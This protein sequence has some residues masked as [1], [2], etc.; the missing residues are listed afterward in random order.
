MQAR[1]PMLLCTKAMFLTSTQMESLCRWEKAL[2]ASLPSIKSSN[3]SEVMRLFTY[4]ESPEMC[5]AREAVT[6][7]RSL[8]PRF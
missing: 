5:S 7:L 3:N 8:T 4:L 2:L 1:T 6:L